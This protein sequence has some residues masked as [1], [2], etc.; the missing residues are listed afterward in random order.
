MRALCK[1]A[2]AALVVTLSSTA[3]TDERATPDEAKTMAIKAAEYIKS[4]GPDVAYKAFTERS[5]GWFDRDLYVFVVRS[6][7]VTLAHGG[8]PVLVGK[9]LASL[10]DVDGKPFI[11]DIVAVKGQGW[12]DYK[13]KN[14]QSQAV[15][16][17]TSYV[18]SV[19]DTAVGVGAYRQ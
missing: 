5:P 10:K 16:Q 2:V 11:V 1:L 17:K 14:P 18:V 19:D 6:D 12:V 4:A 13:W 15:E 9:N 3:L 7:G 8:N